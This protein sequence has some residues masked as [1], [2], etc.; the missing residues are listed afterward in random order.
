[1]GAIADLAVPQG[2]AISALPVPGNAVTPEQLDVENFNATAGPFRQ[3]LRSGMNSLG[4]NI[5]TLIGQTGETL[6]LTEFANDRL[7]DAA[8]FADF[9]DRIGP[10]VR[11]FGAAKSAEQLA[12]FVAG[13]TGEALATSLPAL[14]A[15]LALRRPVA[16]ITAGTLPFSAG[17]QIQRERAN[18]KE[19]DTPG[20]VL[21]HGLEKGAVDSALYAG[22][23]G[24]GQAV[25]KILNPAKA[26][27]SL[28]GAVG[29]GA[30][31]NA[32]AGAGASVAGDVIAKDQP[33]WNTALSAAIG[34]A[35]PGAILAG[36][37]HA[38]AALPGKLA[39]TSDE[40]RTRLGKKEAPPP[41]EPSLDDIHEHMT[42]ED[43]A[44]MLGD[45]EE[46]GVGYANKIWDKVKNHPAAQKYG[47]M[48]TN[49]ETM[50]AFMNDVRSTYQKSTF[51]PQVD[52][53]VAQGKTIVGGIKQ[54]LAKR[55]TEPDESKKSEMRTGVDDD[56]HD[57]MLEALPIDHLEAADPKQLLEL[58]GI[59]KQMAQNPDYFAETG[60]PRA[61]KKVF[62]A[63]FQ[64]LMEK[65][66]ERVHGPEARPTA[67]KA[68]KDT[69]KQDATEEG[70]QLEEA[71][72]LIRTHLKPE[73]LAKPEMRKAAME[74]LAP[75]L[76]DYVNHV[77]H[78]EPHPTVTGKPGAEKMEWSD[79]HH[80]MREAFGDNADK[81]YD[82]LDR[83]RGKG[84]ESPI[85]DE[86]IE[87]G[88]NHPAADPRL[89]QSYPDIATAKETRDDLLKEYGRK[90][91]TIDIRQDE[92]GPTKGAIRLHL[93]PADEMGL[94]KEAFTRIRPKHNKSGLADEGVL[95]VKTD[96][97]PQGTKVSL[98]NLT[99]EMMRREGGH[100]QEGA[101]Y[102]ADMFKRGVASLLATEGFHGFTEKGGL[103][104]G[105]IPDKTPVA[106]M[107]GKLYTYGEIKEAGKL[108][109]WDIAGFTKD[110][111]TKRAEVIKAE[112]EAKGWD[113]ITEAALRKRAVHDLIDMGQRREMAKTL[114]DRMDQRMEGASEKTVEQMHKTAAKADLYEVMKGR[115]KLK[116]VREVEESEVIPRSIG[117]DDMVTEMEKEAAKESD[118]PRYY[119][120]DTGGAI[121]SDLRVKRPDTFEL[122]DGSKVRWD[123]PEAVAEMRAKGV[124]EF[125]KE[126]PPEFAGKS[127]PAPH[128]EGPI[129][130]V[131]EKQR[132]L[133]KE[134]QDSL[135]SANPG[136]RKALEDLQK[137][138]SKKSAMNIG[139]GKV[140]KEQK[141]QVRDYVSKVLGDKDT[142]VMFKKMAHAG[143]FAKLDDVETMKI[144][145][146]AADPMS[147]GYHEALHALMSRL[148]AA[149]PKAAHT[150]LRAAGAAPIVARLRELL[151][152][153][154]EALKQ[155]SDPEERLAYMYQFWASGEKG[156]L[157]IGPNTRTFFDKIKG[158][159]N[160]ITSIWADDS[161]SA[162]AVQRANDLLSAF[163][164][165]EF[166]DRSAVAAVLAKKF[167]PDPETQLRKLWPTVGK[168]MDHVI[169]TA[170]GTVR[171]MGFE[172]LTKIMDKFH[173]TLDAADKEQGYNQVKRVVYNKFMNRV[174]DAM[175]GL[176]E[177]G[178][179]ALV[180]EMQSGKP[181][182]SKAAKALEQI[183]K[184]L[185]KYMVDKGVKSWSDGKYHD[186]KE[187]V[188]N[189]WHRVPN[190][191]YLRTATGKLAFEKMLMKNGIE[192]PT[193][194]YDKWV[195]DADSGELKDSDSVLGLSF[196]TPQ[197]SERTLGKIP[198][199]EMAPFLEKD[200]FGTMSQYVQRAV[201]RAEYTERFGNRGE[202]IERARAQAEKAG[203]TQEQ[204]K[205]FDASVRAH[206]GTLGADIDPKLR[207]TYAALMTY[208][209]IRLLPLQLFSSFVDPLGIMVRGGTI[210]D[211]GSAFVRGLRELV[212]VKKD[213]S[214]DMAK[215]I[216]AIGTSYDAGLASDMANAQFMPKTAK[217]ISE[218]FF[219][220][221][222]MESW[223]RSLRVAA[224]QAAHDFIVRHVKEPNENSTR[225]LE[226]LNLKAKDVKVDKNGQLD[227][228]DPK[229]AAAMNRWV[230]EAILT[231]NAAHRPIY[232]SDPHYMLISHLKQ[233]SYLFQK[234]ILSRVYDEL[235]HKNYSPAFALAGYVPAIIAAD[236]MRIAITPTQNDDKA[237][238]S[239]TTADWLVNGVQRAGIFGPGQLGIGTM[240]DSR[241]G[242]IPGQS[243]AGPTVE[244]G[245][246]LFRAF[247]QR[248][249]V[250]NEIA[251]A[252]PGVKLFKGGGH[253]TETM[254]DE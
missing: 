32:A 122:K 145:I 251:N 93:E 141:Q 17:Q 148:N 50:D 79:F 34:G 167:P 118:K 137:A 41:A 1:M 155:L 245:I 151:A 199:A 163:H 208:Q 174:I 234:V 49:P 226:Q 156:L 136:Y 121:G 73:Y 189:Y 124:A 123:S 185:F 178:Q 140:T 61:L 9:S 76:L 58:G 246:D 131:G 13:T 112:R 90:N 142:K 215:T 149:D 89:N 204:L 18:P 106:F 224:T 132:K 87:D 72:N 217:W 210:G 228:H 191:E 54:W 196:F 86:G 70:T 186:L 111:I 193:G 238:A 108:S 68:I 97:H 202:V 105:K 95:T 84:R 102:V 212:G 173:T 91:V 229:V 12:K 2:G 236:M 188:D 62:G 213:A 55:G 176:D 219:K 24:A 116:D 244:Q 161:S 218:K 165:G 14:G 64:P 153:H 184:D 154:P 180:E 57:A 249:G 203:A 247:A 159:F 160:K 75:K 169:Y 192:D 25:R 60:V 225:M 222:G 83:I 103:V 104:D 170:N 100:L 81:V 69:F 48:A 150:L 15:S 26:E 110:D 98:V 235:R 239:W 120:E 129:S 248:S 194:I 11:D 158:F 206:E 143:E 232:M 126:A 138:I 177:A 200:L 168:L 119:E 197:L 5:N 146:D 237:R 201:R 231:P 78:E 19:G 253:D 39:R 29:E 65:A 30:L 128:G 35:I 125:P 127:L 227:L 250:G 147:V 59:I 20:S 74:E 38:V 242:R 205:V 214:Y 27:G 94:D 47:D 133:T 179:K 3:G 115:R 254:G 183:N 182:K 23:G 21:A 6:G 175:E 56:I 43:V 8:N 135:N 99:S 240:M 37:G 172:P 139:E 157:S 71:Q 221:N 40:L 211:A 63:N 66:V 162:M 53:A 230:N 164:N 96:L 45:Y 216:G 171:D 252:V 4:A 33:D 181:R 109:K 51:K 113:P 16:G 198:D 10:P 22:V 67:M 82:G 77:G 190:Q 7:K 152:D 31:G 166:S 223:N 233:Y 80:A 36:G 42:Q 107:R 44:N 52:A 101:G 130:P 134:V 209:N 207:N 144:S 28:L 92:E 88:E 241:Q 195:A 117:E 85:F 46:K 114:A 220:Y 187:I 243:L